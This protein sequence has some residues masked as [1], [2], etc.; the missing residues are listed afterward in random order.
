MRRLGRLAHVAG[1]TAASLVLAGCDILSLLGGDPFPIDPEVPFP[2]ADAT[3][4][5]GT[6]TV[7][8]EGETITLDQLVGG[9]T[10]SESFGTNVTWT[11]GEGWY[12]TFYGYPGGDGFDEEAYLSLDRL[13][14]SQHWVIYNPERC[15]TTVDANGPDGLS[16]TAVC[17]GLKWSDYFSAFS[18]YGA[19]VEIPGEPAFDADITFEAHEAEPASES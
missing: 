11:N 4:T 5:S 9:G 6:A 16:G 15:V 12:L 18:E 8:L 19:P 1:L 3:F 17:R 7:E 2:S 13:F 14:D 10:L